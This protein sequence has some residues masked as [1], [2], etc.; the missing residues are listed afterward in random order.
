MANSLGRRGN[1]IGIDL[2]IEALRDGWAKRKFSM[3]DLWRHAQAGRMVNVMR[4]QHRGHHRMSA[5]GSTSIRA[6]QAA[7]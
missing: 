7:N 1:K 4:P 2:A 5:Q 3:D 6:C